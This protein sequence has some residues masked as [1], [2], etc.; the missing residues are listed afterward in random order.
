MTR[1][2]DYALIESAGDSYI[3][4][5]YWVAFKNMDTNPRA[6]L[7][8]FR[9]IIEYM[10]DQAG[11]SDPA[12]V[13]T[14]KLVKKI[15]YLF[16]NIKTIAFNFNTI[17]V[18]ANYGVHNP[19]PSLVYSASL[20]GIRNTLQRNAI[21]SRKLIVEIFSYFCLNSKKYQVDLI[22]FISKSHTKNAAAAMFCRLVC[23]AKRNGWVS[24]AAFN[25]LG[26]DEYY[27]IKNGPGIRAPNICGVNYGYPPT[28]HIFISGIP[29]DEAVLIYKKYHP[30]RSINIITNQNSR[31]GLLPSYPE[32]YYD[33]ER[34]E[35][36]IPIN[37]PIIQKTTPC[38]FAHDIEH[39]KKT[40]N[41]NPVSIVSSR[42]EKIE[43]CNNDPLF[44]R[45]LESRDFISNGIDSEY[46]KHM[47]FLAE[48]LKMAGE[49][50]KV[51]KDLTSRC[52]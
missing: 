43:P 32:I 21:L 29:L 49:N 20:R 30:N 4:D 40:G 41:K 48:L 31:I 13:S 33:S 26:H 50:K 18:L 46:D 28:P 36:N 12:Y 2:S 23:Y 35:I 7:V 1:I 37:D 19:L 17:R 44:L 39:Q 38:E 27:V 11:S 34:N 3:L 9:L 15:N 52:T 6:A 51:K 25:K 14:W 47:I 8:N 10:C 5:L 45:G 42:C 22:E 16:E 24:Y